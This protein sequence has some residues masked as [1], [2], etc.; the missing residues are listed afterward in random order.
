MLKE[1]T[2]NVV[3]VGKDKSQPFN[4][5]AKG[6]VVKY[7]GKARTVKH[8]LPYANAGTCPYANTGTCSYA[9]TGTCWLTGQIWV[10]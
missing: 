3:K 10:R 9:N 4:L 6:Q 8:I 1:R 2:F 5:D 7:D